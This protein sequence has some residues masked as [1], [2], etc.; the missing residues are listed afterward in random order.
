MFTI[1][2]EDGREAPYKATTFSWKFYAEFKSEKRLNG[3]FISIIA[4]KIDFQVST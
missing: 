4:K 3:D 2:L 1:N